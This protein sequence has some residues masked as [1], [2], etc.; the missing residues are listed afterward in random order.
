MRYSVFV[1]LVP[2]PAD[3]FPAVSGTLGL[4]ILVVRPISFVSTVMKFPIKKHS[5]V[6]AGRRTAVSLEDAFWEGLREIAKQRNETLVSLVNRINADRQ[7]FNL[8][9]AIRVF[10][11]DYYRNLGLRAQP[12]EAAPTLGAGSKGTAPNP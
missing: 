5:I 3:A 8:S 10:V 2:D 9:S 6:I 11:L 12:K 1:V 4:T 7:L